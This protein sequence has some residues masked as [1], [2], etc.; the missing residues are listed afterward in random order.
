M[1]TM[2]DADREIVHLISEADAIGALLK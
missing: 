2:T 1:L